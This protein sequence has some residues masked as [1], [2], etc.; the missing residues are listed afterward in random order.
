MDITREI[1]EVLKT[2]EQSWGDVFF[3]KVTEK[4][5]KLI[6][7]D[8]IFIGK[9]DIEKMGI[10]TLGLWGKDGHL[11]DFFY[12]LENTPCRN[13]ANDNTCIFEE[14]VTSLFPKDELLIQMG[15]EGYIGSPLKNSRGEVFALMVALFKKKIPH[16]EY[17]LA[18]FEVFAG[19]ISAELEREERERQLQKI[20]QDL[21][22][23]VSQRTKE[24]KS[25]L[26]E[27][28]RTREILVEKEKIASLGSLVSGVAHEIN[29]PLGVSITAASNMEV[30]IHEL[31]KSFSSDSLKKSDLDN[32][33]SR[34]K[35][36][37]I[38][39][40]KNLNR[41][42]ELIN[43]FKRVAVDQETEVI[44]KIVLRE[45][46]D[47]IIMSLEPLTMKRNITI[48]NGIDPSIE[49]ETE[50]GAI[51]Q[52]F[53]NLLMNAFIHGFDEKSGNINIKSEYRGDKTV[54]SI[55]NDGLAVP[56]EVRD[57]IFDPFVTTRRNKGGT[58]LG[59]HIVYNLVSTKL[60]GRIL[61]S[62]PDQPVQFQI[63]FKTT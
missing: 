25:L 46:I 42:A 14:K 41:S 36:S 8:Y 17:V 4:L 16:K 2:A 6:E 58:G 5:G 33:I 28:N 18:L 7:A 15:I 20:N 23:I 1:H 47:E 39:L 48:E 59:L 53:T 35:N 56:V 50:P 52:I 22:L 19:R 60:N 43:R 54:I 27:V 11:D 63:I 24:L 62:N 32:F 38:I 21:E 12:S 40:M 37:A 9:I 3:R 29:T 49:F 44:R 31:E 45:Y 10:N 51:Y 61:L 13:V 55:T 57:K 26:D 30:Q 34:M